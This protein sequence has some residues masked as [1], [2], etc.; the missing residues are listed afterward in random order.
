MRSPANHPLSGCERPTAV[1][2]PLANSHAAFLGA[3]LVLAVIV[4]YGALSTFFA[5]DDIT[6]LSRAAGLEPADWSFRPLSAGL[7]FRLEYAL[8]GL[9]PFGYHLVNLLLHLLNVAGVY[10]LAARLSRSP[11]IA[12]GAAV[13]FG[14]S[15]FAFTPVHW[16]TGV[17]ELLTTALLLGATLLHLHSHRDGSA[18]RWVVAVAALVAMLSKETAVAWVVLILFI[19]WRSGGAARMGRAV[20]PAAAAGVAF[21]LYFLGSRHW[22]LPQ[23]SVA[24]ALTASPVSLTQNLFTYLQWSV[25]LS[26]PIPDVVALP[27]PAAWR[28][29]LPLAVVLVLALWSQRR[30]TLNTFEVGVGWWLAF[31]LPVLPLAH[32]TYLYYLYI[33]A[34]GGAIAVSAIGRELLTRWGGRHAAM[35]GLVALGAYV[36]VEVRNVEVRETVTR[37]ALP[38]DRTI[39]DATLLRH[40]LP[41]LAR[42]HLAPGTR[43]LFVN[44]VPRAAF[45]LMTGAQTRAEDRASRT[46]YLPL[47]AAFREGETLR[48]FI[49][50]VTYL[51]FANTIPR[52]LED[53]EC[54]YYEQRGWL[55][56]LGHGQQALM[57]QGEIQMAAQSW[58]AADSTL[59]RVRAL[60]DTLP[61]ALC[62]QVTCLAAMGR[63]A[64]AR[65]VAEEYLRRWPGDS[66]ATGVRDFL[67]SGQY[68]RR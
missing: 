12:G 59:S 16:A 48:L 27:D 67:K 65:P 13:L 47:E 35:I 7:A 26:N 6:F 30:K 56:R 18:W 10:A 58:A 41:A 45:D 36:L 68:W 50:G 17:I 38:V 2:A 66:S 25:A 19:E 63:T 57:R 61:E 60:G 64:E 21:A 24:Y 62:G 22:Q 51:G 39:R 46:S 31:L 53:A 14:V 42:A 34:V 33:P 9:R 1:A 11:A 20:L 15:S 52:G 32:H 8:F 44:P 28:V 43:V 37:D 4:Y 54:F 40:A 3:A 49:P 29:A 5:Q 55:E 23:P